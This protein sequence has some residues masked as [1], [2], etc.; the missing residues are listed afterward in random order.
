MPQL[1]PVELGAHELRAIAG[2]LVIEPEASPPPSTLIEI[3]RPERDEDTFVTGR[4]LSI[5]PE[6]ATELPGV[7]VGDRVLYSQSVSATNA[8]TRGGKARHIVHHSHVLCAIE[9]P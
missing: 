5:G 6:A 4:V 1:R 2:K 9:A 8:A 3:V 7:K